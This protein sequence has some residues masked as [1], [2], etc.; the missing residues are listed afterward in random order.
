MKSLLIGLTFIALFPT[1]SHGNGYGYNDY[2]TC[3]TSSNG[4]SFSDKSRDSSVARAHA[5]RQCSNHS[6]TS[7]DECNANISC[8]DDAYSNPMVTCA[9]E[10][11]GY[12]FSDVSRSSSLSRSHAI[13][14]CNKHS[15]TSNDECNANVSCNDG[16]YARP[17]V[18]CSTSSN[19]Y[20]FSDKSR[21]KAISWDHAVKQCKNHSRTSNNECSANVTCNDG[22][23]YPAM[24]KCS[25]ESNGYSFS[26][27]S[28]DP[29]ISSSHAISQC[30]K[31]SRTS[32]DECSANLYCDGGYISNQPVPA[33]QAPRAP[34]YQYG[35]VY[36]GFK[37][38]SLHLA[39]RLIALVEQLEPYTNIEEYSEI[40]LPVKKQAGRLKAR[41]NGRA[42]T[43]RVRNT[44]IHLS[45]LLDDGSE[46]IEELTDRDALFNAGV[47]LDTIKESITN[48]LRS[49]DEYK[50]DNNDLY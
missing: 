20:S 44:L 10:S 28:R 9:T 15:R 38:M 6:R 30:K 3:N 42:K 16:S 43:R 5:L 39:T 11:N 1:A 4:Y 41:V 25:T 27:R 48:L 13:K 40:L 14:A 47:E 36:Y 37:G 26:D 8:G 32:N 35:N 21:D 23:S 12:S 7:N 18:K 49:L 31:H 46:Y 2:V 17:M 34:R 24:V 19:G 50:N 45:T 29:S 22:A 33:P